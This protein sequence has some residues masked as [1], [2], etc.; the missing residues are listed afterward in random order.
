M[1]S[2]INDVLCITALLYGCY[3]IWP[4][5]IVILIFCKNK[6]I[7]K[8]KFK[9]IL[10]SLLINYILFVVGIFI[11]TICWRRLEEYLLVYSSTMGLITGILWAAIV[12]MFVMGIHIIFTQRHI[13]EWNV[14]NQ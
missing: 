7:I 8:N 13:E 14:K 3:F 6:T 10:A 1:N 11:L 12:Y 5:I 2:I 4:L 9:F